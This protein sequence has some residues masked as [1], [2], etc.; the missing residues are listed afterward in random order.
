MWAEREGARQADQ[1]A[2]TLPGYHVA[3][4]HGLGFDLAPQSL[5][6]AV[7]SRWPLRA[8]EARR[9]PAPEGLD[10]LRVVLRVEVEGPRGPFD[11]Y[12][13]HL[14]FRLDQSHV[15]QAQVAAICEFVAEASAQRS[16][17]PLLC[18]D[19]NAEP[20]SEE[21]RMLTGLATCPVPK[22][23]FIDAWRA[24]GD[25]GPGHTWDNAN[26]FAALDCEPNRR[27]D[28]LFVGY[29]RDHG[30]GQVLTARLEAT[31]P[32]GG[33]QPSDHYAL[34]AELRY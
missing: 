22:L 27:I 25:G 21:I 12:V 13:T 30:A 10:E 7:L 1:L 11:V 3:E 31:E 33:V 20:G 8:Q 2:A 14:N 23:V 16:F 34:Y 24:G 17:P 29:P 5:G 32:V 26:P 18:G 6:N 19:F 15:R 4:A 9:L 28:Y